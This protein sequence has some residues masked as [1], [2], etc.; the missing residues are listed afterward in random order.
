MTKNRPTYEDLEKRVR[1][2]EK[3]EADHK[4]LEKLQPNEK[5]FIEIALNS[6]LDTFFLFEPASGKAIHWNRAFND[7]TGY[8]DEEIAGMVAP[9]S[10]YS[11]GDLERTDISIQNILKAGTG[12]IEL[13]LICKDGRK[14]PFEYKVSTIKDEQG[15]P[16]YLIAIGR[17]ITE[18]KL[19][20]QELK[21]SRAMYQDLVET[22]QVLVWK[23]DEQGRFTYLNKAWE[24][25]LGYRLDEMLGRVFSEF[26]PDEVVERDRKEFSSHLVGGSVT[27]FETIHLSKTGETR[28]MLF[29]AVPLNDSK[30]NIVGT[31]GTAHDITERK[32]LEDALRQSDMQYKTIGETIPYG[33]WLTDARGYCTFASKSYLE[34]VDMSLEQVQELG[35]LHLL[36][37]E[38][39]EP[40]KEHW[41]HCVQTGEYFEM[42]HRIRAKDGNYRNV[43]AIGRPVRD[44]TGKIVNWVGLNLDVTERK[45]TEEALKE[46]EQRFSLTLQGSNITAF[47]Q[48]KDLRYTWV[49]NQNPG[50]S[51]EEIIGKTDED[52][53]PPKDAAV[54][55]KM[56]RRVLQS[57][58]RE[59]GTM[60]FT[61]GG[62]QFYYTLCLEPMRDSKARIIGIAGTS[63]DITEH[64]QTEKQLKERTHNLGERVKELNCL[65]GLS[66]LIEKP[67][68]TLEEICQGLVELIPP[69]WQYPGITCARITI[70]GEEFKSDNFGKYVS[71]QTQEI[72][73]QGQK[74]GAIDI[75]YLKEMP[76]LDE[77]PFLKEERRLV[78][79]LAERLGRIFERRRAEEEIINLAKFPS[80][81]PNLVMRILENGTIIYA[82]KGSK[83]LLKLWK[84][85]VGESLADK[86]CKIVRKIVT[87][88]TSKNLEI[89]C[90]GRIISLTFYPVKDTGYLNVY[91]IDTTERRQAEEE[92]RKAHDELEMR[93]VER[94]A[95]LRESE[96][97][98][99]NLIENS[100]DLII[101]ADK[102][103]NWTFVSPSA[104]SILGYEPSEMIGRPAFDF[105][106]QEDIDATQTAHHSVVKD[107]KEYWEYTNRWNRKD[108]EMVT[109]EW[110]VMPV[111]DEKGNISGIEGVARDI[112]DKKLAEEKEKLQSEIVENMVES[113]CLIRSSDGVIVYTNSKFDQMFGYD[114]EE[115][116]GKHTS[117]LNAS[118][119]NGPK[120]TAD[121]IIQSLKENGVW[122]GEVNNIK[123]NGVAFWTNSN[124]STFTHGQ[125]G[126]VL[127]AVVEDITGHKRV[128][129]E[130]NK[131]FD[132]PTSLI[133]VAKSDGTIVRA[134]SGWKE[135][136]GY[137]P[138]E[139]EGR[140]YF[141]FVHPDDLPPSEGAA[142]EIVKGS[143]VSNFTNRYRHKDGTYRTL[144]WAVSTDPS[145][146][147][148][149]GVAIDDTE[150]K[151]AEAE[152]TKIFDMPTSLIMVANSDGTIVRVSS[153]WKETL[154]YDPAEMEGRPFFDFIHPDD[155]PSTE[156]V[157]LEI[158]EGSSTDN[159]VN[160][161]R[162]KDGTYRTLTWAGSV[163]LS[164]GLHYGVAIDDTERKAAEMA[165]QESESN[166]KR[167]Q[168]VAHLG[169]W[170]LD[171]VKNVLQWSDENCRIFGIEIGAPNTYETFIGIVHPD[172]R[173]YVNR[174]WVAATRGEPYDID[175]R[176]IVNG[177][178]RW[179]N[180]KADVELD[181]SGNAIY[182]VGTTQD[183][184]S[185]KLAEEALRKSERS[186]ANAQVIARLGSW[187]WDMVNDKVE[188]SDEMYHIFGHA[189]GS[190]EEPTYETFL[191]CVHPGD[192][193][194]VNSFIEQAARDKKPFEFE[195][196]TVP[197]RDSVKILV[198]QGE[199]I[200]DETGTPTIMFGINQDITARKAAEEALRE[201]EEK[202][203]V[204]FN[205]SVAGMY[206]SK[207]G[208][209]T[210]L[211]ANETAARMFGFTKEEALT[212]S[213]LNLYV[214]KN[215]RKKMLDKLRRNGR[216][217]N[218]QTEYKRKD[219]TTFWGEVS[220]VEQVEKG[221]LE[222][223]IID[224]TARKAAEGALRES[225]EKFRS[226]FDNAPVGIGLTTVTGKI[227]A[228]NQTILN[229]YHMDLSEMIEIPARN[230]Y[231]HPEDRDKMVGIVKKKGILRNFETMQ[232]RLD[233][234]T[235]WLSVNMNTIEI[236][237]ETVLLTSFLDISVR[238][239][240][241]KALRESE[242]RFRILADAPFEGIAITE[243]ARIVD[244]N[245]R[246]AA[247][248]GY[249]E[250]E[251][252]SMA[253]MD[254][255][256]PQDRKRILKLIMAGKEKTVEHLAL[257][258]DGTLF[259]ILA[260]GRSFTYLGRPARIT[261]IED[262][263]EQKQLENKYSKIF[264]TNLSAL[265][266]ATLDGTLLDG[267]QAFLD[268][269]GYSLEELRKMTFYDLTPEKWR[270][271]EA[272]IIEN[273]VIKR[274]YSDE[275]EKEYIRKDGSIVPL[276][277]RVWLEKD[278]SGKPL[279]V[280]AS[281]QDITERK[282]MEAAIKE[283][284]D[285]LL[286]YLKQQT[287]LA[288]IASKLNTV[289]S[290]EVILEPILERI[291]EVLH[292]DSVCF[293]LLSENGEDAQKVE[294]WQ[295]G[296][297]DNRV[298]ECPPVIHGSVIP[299]YFE[300]I[301]AGKIFISADI[302]DL[303]PA[304]RKF[305][306]TNGIGTIFGCPLV[307]GGKVK[308][309][310]NLSHSRT[311]EWDESEI[312]LIRA[313]ADMIVNAWERDIQLQ[314]RLE[315]E[316]KQIAAVRIAEK[317]SRLAS[318]GTL[319]AGIAHEINQPLAAL[320]VETEGT[321]YHLETGRKT[322]WKKVSETL[323]FISGQAGRIDGIVS[324]MRAL[325]R[326]EQGKDPVILDIN[327][328][329]EKAL[330][331]VDAQLYSNKI[332][333][334]AQLDENTPLVASQETLLEQVVINL[335][336]NAMH[337]LNMQDSQNK[338]I[339]VSTCLAKSNVIMQIRDN[340]EGIPPEHLG[341][342]FDPFFTTKTVGEGM[343]LGLSITENLINGLGGTIEAS[344]HEQGGAVFTVILPTSQPG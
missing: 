169:S 300:R 41:L 223:V 58:N 205:N 275:Y 56:K 274:G 36:P 70:D 283:E 49:Y 264:H 201:S 32:Q 291:G 235:F 295:S 127:V 326:Q 224:I 228:L 125:Y 92:L 120:I 148:H 290:F 194:F 268:L 267:N 293:R 142:Q 106:H 13:E 129:T 63:T 299:N 107:G 302:G 26:L 317:S 310:L 147:L 281:I 278:E 270:A 202:F 218:F 113:I 78:N 174:C 311:H 333:L 249:T 298:K 259:P 164:T 115:L 9:G 38:D 314:G 336:V 289:E 280:F 210:I 4:L 27:D 135:T 244:C 47:N 254:L 11:P 339:V 91:G 16:K 305:L 65:Y 128:E 46:N 99:R 246:F 138:A 213:S 162:H 237:G 123:K 52:L 89:E 329:I 257:K 102:D 72:K 227:L 151:A 198:V 24:K 122:S 105:M 229:L 118:G 14:V 212:L 307:I 137:D 315:A 155:L 273:Q 131:I 176:I 59:E 95:L 301:R 225:E 331:L 117:M 312:N 154:D 323:K 10:Y 161:Y 8:T 53:V 178:T 116:I 309:L 66:S 303:E 337:A 277:L 94:T 43:L 110:S 185:Q 304:E 276:S 335:V 211:E 238:K 256:A 166:L 97:K 77:G 80:E 71:K 17:D 243:N 149:Y 203:R 114:R 250:A 168:E 28:H 157:T 230:F 22:S 35:W 327:K 51:V 140:P 297:K 100:K 104:K 15:E 199:I 175:H 30:G 7:V 214:N 186:L 163:D 204:L 248:F 191:S 262:L 222:G 316:R 284:Q 75:G 219:G 189:P 206:R 112:T 313:V 21:E 240:A 48:D 88:G 188:W 287:L 90:E 341:H 338:K 258:K 252:A 247:M 29:N 5:E 73:I 134:S 111:K 85:K 109:L 294:C 322:S 271:M 173:E 136:L 216:I 232:K 37:P 150:R 3:L 39:V 6:Q 79:A 152:R 179:V 156:D 82:N 167:A 31:Q 272:D 318:M 108:G 83:D 255:I 344:N 321:L 68:I 74:V 145:T 241:E 261:S 182:G 292:L 171:L 269:T 279:S 119:G 181:E 172:D 285:K 103:A 153:G 146:G 33:V 193:D 25:S 62:K 253:V 132:M 20:E 200:C 234:S 133:M 308:G 231:A 158:A 190:P 324:H 260:H 177:E 207:L 1:E 236:S 67:G 187:S 263:T 183:I 12:T 184:T 44:D 159:F 221:F 50:L 325:A 86:W 342:V 334:V 320:T 226:A 217:D 121:K 196:R 61:V 141:D 340:G 19:A 130:R 54:L 126:Q 64:A 42:E 18:R 98:F 282:K 165:I 245:R 76:E 215:D 208:D 306:E 143:S 286:W 343:G 332:K 60:R 170:Q 23:C 45:R 319:A 69:S 81:N 96:E 34:M 239:Q 288:E 144:T 84:R 209:G 195:F 101:T 220:A 265:G 124:V 328:V 233:G 266:H 87:S 55:T 180:E 2:L 139:M 160:R 251:L 242:E 192:K 93:V 40:T 197:I 57:G 296:W 330:S